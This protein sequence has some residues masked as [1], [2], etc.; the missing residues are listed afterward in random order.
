[1]RLVPLL[2][3]A[4]AL[5]ACSLHTLERDPPPPLAA[6]I[7]ERFSELE[8]DG[9][10]Q[11]ERWWTQFGDAELD[12][13]VNHALADNLDLRR[14]LARINQAEALARAAGAAQ[15]PSVTAN[16]GVSGRRNVFNLGG[17]IGVISNE[18]ALYSL[19]L[20]A[21]WEVDLFNRLGHTSDA[22]DLDLAATREDKNA[23][24]M[25]LAARVTE[26]YLQAVGER[27]L[28]D[29]LLAQ[30]A[31]AKKVVELVELRFG[32][33][34]AAISDVYAQR[35]Q[36]A[37]LTAQR[38]LAEARLQ[39]AKHQLATLIGRPPSALSL[40]DVRALPP[41]PATPKAGVP[42]E[43]LNRRPDVRAAL[44]RVTAADHRVGAA[45]A[46]QYPSLNLSASTGFQAPDLLELFEYWVWNLA[47]N[48]VAPLFDGGRRSAEVDRTRAVLEDL[49]L[50]YGQ[51]TLTAVTEVESA[52]AQESRQRQHVERLEDQLELARLAYTETEVRYAS[53]LS[54]Y[55]EVLTAQR[56]LQQSEQS[57][58]QARRQLL[59]FRVQ[60]HRALGGTWMNAPNA[61]TT[62]EPSK[63]PNDR[64]TP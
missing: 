13:L 35:Q 54:T 63:A 62:P 55:L 58:L 56:A 53:G 60:L 52:L 49:V 30:E 43:L 25:S 17:P 26:L 21:A 16:A 15:L 6:P 23:L 14:A 4:I 33:G 1:M 20:S 59:S 29:L 19:G 11:V 39:V 10:A 51:A 18:E 34:L 44:L 36:L 5:P 12:T 31:S 40:A 3:M 7:P 47:A 22:A 24:A 27:A 32:Q 50:A 48:L 64:G 45:I 41:V 28:I 42:A 46:A 8:A 2:L 38:P 61:A 57:M 9:D 37:T